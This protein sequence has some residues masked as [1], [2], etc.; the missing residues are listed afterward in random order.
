MVIIDGYSYVFRKTLANAIK[1]YKCCLTR[2][3]QCKAKIKLSADDAFLNQLSEHTHP[4]SQTRVKVTQIK[5]RI[6]DIARKNDASEQILGGELRNVSKATA[7]ALPSLDTMRRNIDRQRDDHNMPAIR[8]KTEH[9]SVLPNNYPK[10]K[11][12]IA[13]SYLIVSRM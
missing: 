9:I 4:P 13:F 5:A 3:G 8:Q 6:K 10:R 11:E 2:K 7:V 12:E 1:C